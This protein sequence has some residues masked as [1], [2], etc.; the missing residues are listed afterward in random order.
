MRNGIVRHTFANPAASSGG[1]RERPNS[2]PR[3][4]DLPFV[5]YLRTIRRSVTDN[6]L[7]CR[8]SLACPQFYT[9][10]N[11][12]REKRERKEGRHVAAG[13]GPLILRRNS[14]GYLSVR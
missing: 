9:I 7:V 3:I 4:Y 14:N 11:I 10:E 12:I 6:L 13:D 5:L 8:R 1:M 2:N